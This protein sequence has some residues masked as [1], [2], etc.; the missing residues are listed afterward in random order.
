MSLT[1]TWAA[2]T[3][4]LAHTFSAFWLR[5]SVVSVL[6]SLI[7][8]T[9]CIASFE[10][11]SISPPGLLN[12][13]L[14]AWVATCGLGV[15]LLPWLHTAFINS[16]LRLESWPYVVHYIW[17]CCCPW[18]LQLAGFDHP[19]PPVPAALSHCPM[20]EWHQ[21][22]GGPAWA[23]HA[24]V[25]CVLFPIWGAGPVWAARPA[26]KIGMFYSCDKAGRAPPFTYLGM[27][28]YGKIAA[29]LNIGYI[30]TFKIKC[31]HTWWLSFLMSGPY[32]DFRV[33]GGSEF[34]FSDS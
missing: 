31:D 11:N 1:W 34:P 13:L 3:S 29:M 19:S 21:G 14:A 27:A 32:H 30:A 10:I 20:A 18:P 7:S 25:H 15:A 12:R 24:G 33:Q 22:A 16:K 26:T 2:R 8:D 5:S 23:P 17:W 6:I 9:R 4:R 28:R